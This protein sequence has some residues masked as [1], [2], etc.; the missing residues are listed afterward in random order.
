[1][2]VVEVLS[3]V[4]STIK[5]V[6]PLKF[7]ATQP[8]WKAKLSVAVEL[9]YAFDKLKRQCKVY[10]TILLICRKMLVTINLIKI[11]Q[12]NFRTDLVRECQNK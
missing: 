7:Q 9:D 12:D 8:R 6:E 5:G 10:R 3:A 2:S 4:H 1:M 11:A